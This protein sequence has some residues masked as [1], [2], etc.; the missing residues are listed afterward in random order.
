MRL[1]RKPPRRH[2]VLSAKPKP[3]ATSPF[4]PARIGRTTL[5][6]AATGRH[7]DRHFANA[8]SADMNAMIRADRHAQD[9]WNRQSNK[10]DQTGMTDGQADHE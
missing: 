10:T 7:F 9:M 2:S 1:K 3:G 5:E 8:S 6:P 4:L